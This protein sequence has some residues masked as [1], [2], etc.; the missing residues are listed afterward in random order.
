MLWPEPPLI[1]QLGHPPGGGGSRRQGYTLR[2][3]RGRWA[4]WQ[5]RSMCGRYASFRQAQ[6]LADAFAI[7]EVTAA[8]AG[9]EPSFN[10]APTQQVRIALEA[11]E[12]KRQMHAARWGLVPPWATDPSI[13]NRMINARMETAAEKRSFA[14]SLAKRRCIV[15][16]DG[17]YEWQ[18]TEHG[19]APHFIHHHDATPMAMAGL[20]T[21]WRDPQREDDDPARWVLSTTVLTRAAR[22]Y[23]A[24]LHDREPVVLAPEAVDPWLDPGLT[25]SLDALAIAEN[26]QAD[27]AFHEVSREVGNVGNDHA[28][29]IEPVAG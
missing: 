25:T 14:P 10:V 8:A 15:L 19:K 5:A 12:G 18:R 21:F 26:G 27:L 11:A 24:V 29:L 3:R 1:A 16:G 6:D 9:V 17:Y 23:L 22:P 7:T 13:G 28:G 20:Y 4:D 2:V